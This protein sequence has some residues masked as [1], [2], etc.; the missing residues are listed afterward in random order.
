MFFIFSTIVKFLF[1]A[2]VQNFN[3]TCILLIFIILN[4][5]TQCL[6]YV[7]IHYFFESHLTCVD[8]DWRLKPDLYRLLSLNL[9]WLT[10]IFVIS[11]IQ[12][13]QQK[14]DSP[15]LEAGCGDPPKVLSAAAPWP[16]GLSRPGGEVGEGGQDRW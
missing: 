7:F 1:S 5:H 15:T 8:S 3:S 6:V 12:K 16:W 14:W 13:P 4:K 10:C 11:E 9:F 2:A